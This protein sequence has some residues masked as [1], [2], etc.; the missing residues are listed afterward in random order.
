M[1]KTLVLSFLKSF[2]D[3]LLGV[4]FQFFAF[5]IFPF[6]LSV[7]LS[8]GFCLFEKGL[9]KAQAQGLFESTQKLKERKRSYQVQKKRKQIEIKKNNIARKNHKKQREKDQKIQRAI[10][11]NFRRPPDR[12][13]SRGYGRFVRKRQERE[14]LGEKRRKDYVKKKR[15]FQKIQEGPY[16]IDKMEAYELDESKNS[17][18][19]SDRNG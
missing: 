2:I 1:K 18:R 11:Q 16:S 8:A 4:F 14:F 12:D 3:S 13:F 19:R 10:R 7:F 9:S 6:T 15:A 5:F 17:M